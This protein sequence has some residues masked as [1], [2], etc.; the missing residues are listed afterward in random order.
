MFKDTKFSGKPI[1]SQIIN[2]LER[3]KIYRTAVKHNSDRYCKKFMTI[4]HLITMLYAVLSGCNSLREVE[5]IILACRGRI[6][7]LGLRNFPKRSTL[8][9]ANKRRPSKIFEEIYNELYL[10]YRTHLP[11][12]QVKKEKIKEL[13]IIDSTTIS[14][15][16]EIL[17]GAGRNKINGKKK[18]GIKVHTMISSNDDVPVFVRFTSAATHDHSFLKHI[19]LQPGSIAVFDRAYIDYDQFEYWT[20]TGVHFV[21]RLKKNAI[22]EKVE[23]YDI[24]DCADSGVIID[25]KI[26]LKKK[27]KTILLRKVGYWDDSGNRVFEFVTN[28][29]EYSAE[30]I[31]EIYKRRWQIEVLFKRL[32]QNFPLKYF[33]GD[34]TNAIEIQIWASLIAQLLLL[35]IH[36]QTKRKWSFS[37]LLSIIRFHLMT[38]IHLIK[39]LNNPDADWNYLKTEAE[40]QLNLFNSS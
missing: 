16:G 37:N 8:S 39:F 12:S 10:K 33:L 6:N 28:N 2:L 30:K 31:A 27:D 22:Y 4:D 18:G 36:A 1:I 38:Y 25:E 7:H 9:D 13:K 14:L 21:T 32:K 3:Q 5:S 29:F 19:N 24:P 26:R 23:E 35:V 34:S 11:D 40:N 15:F 17:K 20:G